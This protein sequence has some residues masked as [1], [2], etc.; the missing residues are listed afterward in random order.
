MDQRSIVLYLARKG[1]TSMEIDNGLVATLGS[2]AKVYSSVTRFFHEAKFPW[3]NPPTTFSRENPSLDDSNE[4]ILLALTEQ[5][6][7]SVRQLS[8]LTQMS[9]STVYRRLTQT[10]EFHV[11]DLR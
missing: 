2:D 3:P 5:P 9:R 6:F 1:L 8:R 4:A 7:A 10:L 11:Y